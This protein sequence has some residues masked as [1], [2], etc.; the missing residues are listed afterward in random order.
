MVERTRKTLLDGL[1]HHGLSVLAQTW[2]DTATAQSQTQS[3]KQFCARSRSCE[4]TVC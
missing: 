4:R 2:P 3:D 1:E